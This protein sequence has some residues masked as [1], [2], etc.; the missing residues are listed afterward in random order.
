MN[1]FEAALAALD[2]I[3]IDIH[4]LHIPHTIRVARA[5][6][7][8]EDAPVTATEW[9]VGILDANPAADAY[10][11]AGDWKLLVRLGGA[12]IR[13]ETGGLP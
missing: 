10:V 11:R 7:I 2:E 12:C 9:A 4:A 1:A 3:G 13:H 6:G 8:P 5:P